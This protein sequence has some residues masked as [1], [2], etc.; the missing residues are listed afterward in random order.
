MICTLLHIS[1]SKI[2]YADR[3]SLYYAKL[4][5][6]SNIF[7][8][9]NIFTEIFAATSSV[10]HPCRQWNIIPLLSLCELWPCASLFTQ[11]FNS[12]SSFLLFFASQLFYS[13]ARDSFTTILFRFSLF[14]ELPN[15]NVFVVSKFWG[16]YREQL[17]CIPQ[18]VT[19]HTNRCIVEA[20]KEHN[21]REILN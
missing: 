16:N 21:L 17:Y 6:S 10:F 5:L 18:K 11:L 20:L 3:S 15:A 19:I 4:L 13:F 12:F 9:M 8:R 7:E 14:F 1:S 2:L